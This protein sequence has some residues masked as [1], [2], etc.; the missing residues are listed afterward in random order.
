MALRKITSHMLDAPKGWPSP[1]AVDFKAPFNSTALGNL[2]DGAAFEGRCVHLNANGEYEYGVTAFQMPLFLLNNSDDADVSNY[3]GDI[4]QEKGAWN[5]LWPRGGMAALVAAGAYE[6]ATTEYDTA[7]DYKPNDHLSAATGT[8]SSAGKLV[9]NHS[10]YPATS[11]VGVVSR[12]V[13]KWAN[14]KDQLF[15]WPVYLPAHSH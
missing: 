2:T 1:Y 8:S 7:L 15:F 4:N 14:G 11:I 13:V 10:P 12:G 3:G 5:K 9:N 6:L